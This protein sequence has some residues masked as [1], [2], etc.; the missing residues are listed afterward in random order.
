MGRPKPNYQQSPQLQAA[1]HSPFLFF[2]KYNRLSSTDTSSKIFALAIAKRKYKTHEPRYHQIHQSTNYQ[3]IDI[4]V[5]MGRLKTLLPELPQLQ[6]AEHS[7]FHLIYKYNTT[8]VISTAWIWT[9]CWSITSQT[10]QSLE[11]VT[12][13]QISTSNWKWES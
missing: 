2:Y 12:S 13:H 1:E 11:T 9:N 7:S 8:Q 10:E 5:Q 4:K 3:I 6:V